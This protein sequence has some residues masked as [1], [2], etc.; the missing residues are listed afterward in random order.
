MFKPMV[1]VRDGSKWHYLSPYSQGYEK[2][3]GVYS[4]SHAIPFIEDELH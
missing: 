3:F 2:A 4:I 1:F